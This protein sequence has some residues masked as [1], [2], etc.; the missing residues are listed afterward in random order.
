MEEF[1]TEMQSNIKTIPEDKKRYNRF[2]ELL[3]RI[4]VSSPAEVKIVDKCDDEGD[5]VFEVPMK[6]I[7]ITY[8]IL[9]NYREEISSEFVAN[10]VGELLVRENIEKFTKIMM[11]LKDSYIEKVNKYIHRKFGMRIYKD[12][13]ILRF[14]SSL[15]QS[16][17]TEDFK[18]TMI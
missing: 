18:K 5:I 4:V 15:V 10:F 2:R 16:I 17:L 8:D 7:G 6:S 3:T 11:E 1:V 9:I 12:R 14:H 13:F